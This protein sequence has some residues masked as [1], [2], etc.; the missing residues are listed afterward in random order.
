MAS[1]RTVD[2]CR[3]IRGDGEQVYAGE[4]LPCGTH[5]AI[6]EANIRLVPPANSMEM[7]LFRWQNDG[8][9]G[10]LSD[11]NLLIPASLNDKCSEVKDRLHLVR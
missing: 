1:S 2:Y 3:L 8:V 7:W 4:Y 6:A 11:G 9:I 10:F 5:V